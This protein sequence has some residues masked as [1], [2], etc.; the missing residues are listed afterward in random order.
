MIKKIIQGDRVPI[1]IWSDD[2]EEGALEQAKHLAALPFAYHHI[3]VMPDVHEGY[4]M[5]IGGV[6]ATDGNVVPNAVG[7]DIGCGMCAVKTDL[8]NI[9]IENLKQV[10]GAIRKAIPVGYEHHKSPQDEKYL[11]EKEYTNVAGMEREAS[12]YQIGTLGGGNH[13][14]EIQK[15]SDNHIWLMV[16]SG[17]RN[18]GKKVADHYNYL[19]IEMNR[20]MKSKIPEEWDLAYLPLDT[21]EA[22]DYLVDMKYCMQFAFAS[23]Q[24]MLERIIGFVCNFSGAKRDNFGE[25]VNI[26]HN[27]AAIER[28]FGKEVV[29]HRKGATLATKETIGI[30]PG[31]QGSKSYIVRGKGN[32][33]SFNSCSHGAGRKMGRNE[34]VRTLNFKEEV[35]KLDKMGVLHA[36]RHKKDLEEAAGAYKDIDEVMRNQEDLAEILI[37]L[38]PLG[39][40]KG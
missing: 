38:E 28:H 36:I 24:L 13:F 4:G 18:I 7:V 25:L 14:I 20:K 19:A 34:A 23:R 17:S 8:L 31:S 1:K 39:V 30:I 12:L 26:S 27:Y 33:E 32:P 9:E 21:K 6:L 2:I 29:V 5:P 11:P 3:A 22:G 37:E 35:E 16:H 15:G 10:M 40:V